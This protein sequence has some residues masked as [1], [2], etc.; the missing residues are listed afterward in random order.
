VAPEAA[1]RKPTRCCKEAL[2][3]SADAALAQWT[4]HNREHLVLLRPGRCGLLL[5]TL[6]YADEVWAL[7]E[8][9]TEVEWQGVGETVG[10]NG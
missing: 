7:D 6:F 9:R 10:F 8:F 4:C 3:R 2:R 1:R 5:H